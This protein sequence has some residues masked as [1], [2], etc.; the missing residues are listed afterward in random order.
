MDMSDVARMGLDISSPMLALAHGTHQ[1]TVSLNLQ[2]ASRLLVLPGP[3]TGATTPN[4]LPAATE[5]VIAL[6][7]GWPLI[8]AFFWVR[9]SAACCPLPNG[10]ERF[11]K[12]NSE[13]ICLCD[14]Y[15]YLAT[16]VQTATQLR[17]L[18]G[19]IV[20]PSVIGRVPIP[21]EA[22]QRVLSAQIAEHHIALSKDA[23]Q[24][25]DD[26]GAPNSCLAQR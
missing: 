23:H 20:I 18:L 10:A 17:V 4:D 26:A 1:I 24:V 19:P 22:F 3:F 8:T 9:L 15:H 25:A 21:G 11:C 6:Q 2:R 16:Q 13:A 14:L 7:S 12:R 5:I